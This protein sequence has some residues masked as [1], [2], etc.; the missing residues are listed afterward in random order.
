MA[1]GKKS[2]E[3]RRAAAAKPPP[4]QS[5]GGTRARQASPKVLGGVAG[6][7]LLIV[8]AVVLAVVLTGGKKSGAPKNVPAVGSI[9]NGLPGAAD[10]QALYK[11]IP[12]KGLVLGSAFAPVTMV[13]YV[14]LQCPYCREFETQAMPTLISRYVRTGKL[15]V[16]ARPIAFI[17]PDSARGRAAAIAAGEQ[18][19][20][21]DLAQLLY[22]NQGVENTGWLDD[23][24]V[25]SAAASI[26]ALDVPRLLAEQSSRSTSME[27]GRF[28]K[29]ASAD[30]VRSTPTILVGRSGQALRPV[31][32]SAPSD[33]R[34]VA[35][36]IDAALR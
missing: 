32:L 13:E 4:V 9:A 3:A 21:F 5:K 11:G 2:R 34:A 20:M 15:K 30:D 35:A 31:S 10:V 24:M 33:A 23:R 7:L 16:D 28:D 12:Q 25:E 36:A 14:D 29:Q 17:G 6:V 22:L 26:P 1:S 19:K 27:A 8:V 18:N